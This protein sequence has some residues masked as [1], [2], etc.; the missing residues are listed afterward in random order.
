VGGQVTVTPNPYGSPAITTFPPGTPPSDL[1]PGES[2]DATARATVDAGAEGVM[3]VPNGDGTFSIT[4]IEAT[5]SGSTTIRQPANAGDDLKNHEL[6]HDTLFKDEYD[7]NAKRKAETAL[8]ELLGKK[9]NSVQEMQD[10]FSAT[11][12]KAGAAIEQQMQTLSDKYDKLTHHGDGTGAPTNAGITDAKK[13]RDN[14]KPAGQN[15]QVPNIPSGQSSNFHAVIDA[16]DHVQFQGT[17]AITNPAVAS[18]PINTR[19][20][21]VIEPLIRIGLQENGSTYLSDGHLQIVDSVTGNVLLDGFLFE[22]AI[23][24]SSLPGYAEM[25][26]AYLDIPPALAGGIT[27]SIGSPLLA[28]MDAEAAGGVPFSFWF[29]ANGSLAGAGGTTGDAV[30]GAVPE[31]GTLLLV[32]PALVLGL[33]PMRGRRVRI[34]TQGLGGE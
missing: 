13:E 15:A 2:A 29:F 14:A 16:A 8:K 32:I 7:K 19:G 21:L 3:F 1:K 24:P 9:F 4:K 10:A 17:S 26:Q 25:I 30:I 28:E 11:L 23:M 34:I 22:A 31:P 27:N 12:K 20:Q 6:G 18:D 33:S 5:T